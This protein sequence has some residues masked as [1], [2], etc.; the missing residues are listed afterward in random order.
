MW[1]RSRAAQRLEEPTPRQLATPG[2][3]LRAVAVWLVLIGAEVA[4]GVLR[5]LY[6]TPR[7]GDLRA[8]QIGVFIGSALILIIA[9]LAARW[10]RARTGRAQLLVGGVWLALTLFF[11]VALGLVVL[12]YSWERVSSDYDIR[13]G[14]LLPFGLVVLALAPWLTARSGARS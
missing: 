6:L 13:R 9:R 8:R 10:L 2:L 3:L 1:R 14:G 4:H 12:G 5:T 11:E 7:V